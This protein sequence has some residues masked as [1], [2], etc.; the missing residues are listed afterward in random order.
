MEK[1]GGSR[2]RMKI[3]EDK[4]LLMFS[5]I[6]DDLVGVDQKLKDKKERSPYPVAME[7]AR[8]KKRLKKCNKILML[9]SLLH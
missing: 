3:E 2:W 9:I 7:T 1:D 5:A 6:K 4:K 8:D